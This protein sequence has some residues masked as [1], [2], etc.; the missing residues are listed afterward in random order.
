LKTLDFL[1]KYLS[2]R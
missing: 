1:D 2:T